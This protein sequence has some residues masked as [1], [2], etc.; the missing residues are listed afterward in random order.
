MIGRWQT[1]GLTTLALFL[2]TCGGGGNGSHYGLVG[3]GNNELQ[4]YLPPNAQ[5]ANGLLTITAHQESQGGYNYT[6]V[7]TDR[8]HPDFATTLH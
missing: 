8:T 7:R 5:I 4:W 1:V 2:I 3:W 6:S